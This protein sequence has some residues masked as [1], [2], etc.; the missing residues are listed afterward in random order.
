EKKKSFARL[1]S[2]I[3]IRQATIPEIREA[4][5]ATNSISGSCCTAIS[6]DFG[7]FSSI[8]AL[9]PRMSGNTIKKE[10]LAAFSLLIPKAKDVAMVD[11]ERERPGRSAAHA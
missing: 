8:L 7:S 9:A 2:A 10:K 5:K 3:I 6:P 4:V 1:T 11:P